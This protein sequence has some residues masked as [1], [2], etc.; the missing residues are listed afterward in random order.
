VRRSAFE[1]NLA[2][3]MARAANPVVK[4]NPVEGGGI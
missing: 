4:P 1:P 2:L 3:A